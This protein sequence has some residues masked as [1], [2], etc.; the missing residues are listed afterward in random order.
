MEYDSLCNIHHSFIREIRGSYDFAFL[1]IYPH[2][3]EDIP[4]KAG[5]WWLIIETFNNRV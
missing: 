3:Y 1:N 5:K 4:I 2:F